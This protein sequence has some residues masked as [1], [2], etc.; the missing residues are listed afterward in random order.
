[1]K[2]ATWNVNSIRSRQ[3][4]VVNWLQDNS[5][6]V[7]CLQE[8]KVVDEDFPRSPFESL[9]YHLY[10]SGQKSYNGVALFSQ[11]PL[12]A[13]ST[14]FAGVLPVAEVGDLDEQKRVITG[15][16]D[17]IR[18]VNLYVP[19]GA[20]VGS[21]KYDY[22]LRWLNLLREYVQSLLAEQPNELCICGDFNIALE[23]RD[24]YKPKDK[25]HIM[26]SP[27][28]RQALQDVLELGLADAF[29]KFTPEEGHFTWWD[30][31]QGGFSRNRGWRIDHHYL[32]SNLYKRTRSC[33]IDTT[34]RKLDKPSDHAPVIVEF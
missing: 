15:I 19:N 27:A 12:E 34:P 5:V 31:R 23:D 30:Y 8:T 9:G 2:I 28:E 32:T 22:K 7:L 1:M 29:R 26:A 10:N 17:G 13:V 16:I 4:Q 20:S 11:K 14:G 6:D 25:N 24:I 18:V 3:E 21:D 33:R